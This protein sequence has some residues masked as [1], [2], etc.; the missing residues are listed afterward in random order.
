MS[1]AGHEALLKAVIQAIPAFVMSCF[2]LPLTTCDKMKSI[3]A[4]RWWGVEDGKK[5]IHWR[6]WAWL[7]TPKGLGGM[8]F[9]DLALFNQ[10]LLA[11]QGWRLLTDPESLC[12]RVLKGRYFPDT[13]FWHA[14]KPRS[15]SYTWRSIL[16]G[17]D[18][19]VQGLRWGIGDGRTVKIQ[20]D[21]WV[22]RYPPEILKPTSPIPANATVHCLLDDVSKGWCE[23]TVRAFFSPSVAAQILKI[24]IARHDREDFVCWPFTK[25][26]T[27]TVKSAYNLARSSKFFESQSKTGKGSAS[28]EKEME[29][30]WKLVWKIKAPG[31]MKIHLW[32]FAHNCLPSGMQLCKRQVP[33]TGPCIFCGRLEGIEHSLLSC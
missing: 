4:N 13:D 16:H 29:K 14:Q 30:N 25:H 8:G 11:K 21:N 28:S 31:K 27:Y 22:P 9:R 7:S 33:E 2:Q 24:P 12:S 1:R 32:R 26:G 3:I 15:S 18:L 20:S 17:R 6:S 5:K 10:A 19:L 23:E